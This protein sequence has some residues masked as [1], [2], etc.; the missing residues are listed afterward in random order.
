MHHDVLGAAFGQGRGTHQRTV[1]TVKAQAHLGGHRNVRGDR[2]A[3]VLDDPVEQLRLLEQHRAATGLVHGFG[4]A[5]EVQVDHLGPQL[6]RQRRVFR[7]AHRV[8]TQQLHAQRHAGS[9]L[10][11]VQQFRAELVEIGWRQQLIVDPDELGHAPIDTANTGQ[12]V[13][14][15]V[16]D[17]PLHGRQSNL[18]GK[19]STKNVRQFT[20]FHRSGHVG[21]VDGCFA[22]PWKKQRHPGVPSLIAR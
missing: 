9:G 12:H 11:T 19:H 17:Q 6:T 3:N 20:G 2:T 4:R 15:D 7:Q 21:Q 18:H 13:P 10:G 22:G 5:T 8:G 16:V 14:Q 1:R